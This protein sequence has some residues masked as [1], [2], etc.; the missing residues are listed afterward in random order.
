MKRPYRTVR[1][2][3]RSWEKGAAW[4]NLLA[5]Q[6]PGC[7]DPGVNRWRKEH[8]DTHWCWY[9]LPVGGSLWFW[10]TEEVA[11]SISSARAEL[12]ARQFG[13]LLSASLYGG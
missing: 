2:D 8:T 12:A 5:Q 1:Y 9:Y 10:P 11:P 6:I 3:K 4:W 13:R 7:P